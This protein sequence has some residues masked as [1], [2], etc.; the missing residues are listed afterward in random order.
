MKQNAFV[1]AVLLGSVSQTQALEQKASSE[2]LPPYWDGQYSKTWKYSN[3]YWR[4]TNQKE[5]VAEEPKEYK[6]ITAADAKTSAQVAAAAAASAKKAAAASLVQE[7]DSS[8]DDSIVGPVPLIPFSAVQVKTKHMKAKHHHPHAAAQ[9]T[10]QDTNG[11]DLARMVPFKS[12]AERHHQTDNEEP[13]VTP[14]QPFQSFA[15]GQAQRH[16]DSNDEEVNMAPMQP[17]QSFAQGQAQRHHDSNDE[18]VNMAPMQP[19]Q[20]FA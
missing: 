16:H 10:T 6:V 11:A 4:V 14:I 3:P 5:Y 12:F 20:S 17:F 8:D 2:K 9:K 18:E 1:I 15:Q 19:F 13:N 7:N